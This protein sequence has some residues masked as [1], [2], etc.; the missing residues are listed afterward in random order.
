MQLEEC[1]GNGWT[2]RQIAD[3][4]DVD[5]RTVHHRLRKMG[6]PAGRPVGELP[7]AEV[8]AAYMAGSTIQILADS[9][10]TTYQAVRR[11]LVAGGVVIRRGARPLVSKYKLADYCQRGF[12]VGEIAA[13]TGHSRQTIGRYL[14]D[15]GRRAADKRPGRERSASADLGGVL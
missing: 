5:I 10:G 11:V 3:A 12:S 9:H 7:L 1:H 4:Y 8:I 13:E 6:A 2:P 14:A 15:A